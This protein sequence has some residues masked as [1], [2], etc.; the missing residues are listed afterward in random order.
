MEAAY[1]GVR[2]NV[3]EGTWI[4][5]RQGFESDR[6]GSAYEMNSVLCRLLHPGEKETEPLV[7]DSFERRQAVVDIFGTKSTIHG[8]CRSGQKSWVKA[9]DQKKFRSPFRSV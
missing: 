4:P 7:D 6:A 5:W 9:E 1:E 2:K 8:C 3:T